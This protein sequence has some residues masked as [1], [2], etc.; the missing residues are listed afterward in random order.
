MR[1]PYT[2]SF[3]R[4]YKNES[5]QSASVIVPLVCQLVRPKR[6]ID[7][8]C[9]IGTWL[10]AFV[11]YG[12]SFVTGV[13]GD[14]VDRSLLL[15]P[16]ER[17]ISHNLSEAFSLEDQYDLA[18]SL[19]VAEH[20]PEE[21]ASLFV[22]TLTGLA[23]V[24]LFS[25]AIPHQGGDG[26]VNEQWPEYWIELFARRGY[27][28]IDSIRDRVWEN[29]LVAYYYAQNCFLFVQKEYL[30]T[31]PVLLGEYENSRKECFARVHPRKWEEAND[32]CRQPLK[33]VLRALPTSFA[34]AVGCRLGLSFNR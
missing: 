18:L 20:I 23:P 13:D 32:P 5:Q 17:F 31:S 2:Q 22:E 10:Q 29:E 34:K 28:V 11:E 14:Y 26:H 24:V 1:N 3:Y 27:L 6:V 9:G 19:E 7:V 16:E 25:A 21:R 33:V 8:G 12:V 15:F 4:T 30:Q